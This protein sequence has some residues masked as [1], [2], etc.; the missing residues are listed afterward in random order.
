MPEKNQNKKI[1]WN[2]E[3]QPN[4]TLKE[5]QSESLKSSPRISGLFWSVL[6]CRPKAVV[7]RQNVADFANLKAWFDK[8]EPIMRPSLVK[9][10]TVKN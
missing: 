2:Y 3:I 4:Q 9:Y 8:Y 5:F 1:K 6:I 7:D 10:F